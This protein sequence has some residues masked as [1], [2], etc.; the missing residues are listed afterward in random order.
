[1]Q[2]GQTPS[3]PSGTGALGGIQGNAH[4]PLPHT[5][6]DSF[7]NP[8]PPTNP[9][10][11]GGNLGEAVITEVDDKGYLYDGK[12][13]ERETCET[14]WSQRGPSR[15]AIG[16]KK[17]KVAAKLEGE[18]IAVSSK[19]GAIM[20]YYDT[21]SNKYAESEARRREWE[22]TI[23][24]RKVEA[25]LKIR[26]WEKG[27]DFSLM[28]QEPHTQPKDPHKPPEPVVGPYAPV[29]KSDGTYMS[30]YEDH[31]YKPADYDVS[32]YTSVYGKDCA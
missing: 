16:E 27:D 9:S 25:D 22:E 6:E 11:K 2:Y 3:S 13:L 14:T 23:N 4:E 32:E 28:H 30:V 5:E 15:V 29:S 31:E 18:K 24:I 21:A 26:A 19:R 20:T 17:G 12:T 8:P 10:T 7:L 1:M